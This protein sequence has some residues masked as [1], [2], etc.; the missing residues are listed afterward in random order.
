MWPGCSVS[1]NDSLKGGPVSGYAYGTYMFTSPVCPWWGATLASSKLYTCVCSHVCA[2]TKQCI[3]EI[4]AV[5]RFSR[6]TKFRATSK[7]ECDYKIKGILITVLKSRSNFKVKNT[8]SKIMVPSERSCHKQEAQRAT[9]RAPEY[10]VPPFWGICQGRFFFT[11]WPEKY[12]LGKG[13]WDLTSCQ[14]SLNSVQ[15]FQ[16]RSRKMSQLIRGQG[17]HL[18]FLTVPKKHKLGRGHYDLASCQVSMNYV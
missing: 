14:V 9:Y 15:W 1:H 18:V 6:K 4:F 7:Y 11:D 3:T 5:F 10:N 13:C 8:R 12:K 17:G 2:V 16:R